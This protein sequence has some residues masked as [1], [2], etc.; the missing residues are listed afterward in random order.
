MLK[1]TFTL[2]PSAKEILIGMLSIYGID[3]FEEGSYDVYLDPDY[4]KTQFEI[5]DTID[6]NDK[7]SLYFTDQSH[8]HDLLT[9]LTSWNE[10][11]SL[12]ISYQTEISE[13]KDEDWTTAW[14]QYLTPIE[15]SERLAIIPSWYKKPM[16]SQQISIIIDPQM[17]FGTGHHATTW[18]CLEIIDSLLTKQSF[19]KMLDVGCGTGILSFAAAKFGVAHVEGIDIDAEAVQVASDNAII[20]ECPQCLFHTTP[21]SQIESTFD[22]VCANYI[23]KVHYEFTPH[24]F[25]KLAPHSHLILSGILDVEK[26]EFIE[27][28]GLKN[29]EIFQ[30]DEWIA[31]LI[32]N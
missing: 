25:S 2:T 19:K 8:I 31:F 16:N 14:Q 24:I 29:F 18:L 5:F 23:T 11:H 30:R 32:K 9:F 13:I 6:T 26:D 22:L 12:N 3:T 10:Q 15:I 27:R 20:N 4:Q 21:I 1:I 28:L 17:A 7:I